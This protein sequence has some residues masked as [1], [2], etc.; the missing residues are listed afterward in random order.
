VIAEHHKRVRIEPMP[1]AVIYENPRDL[2]PGFAVRMWSVLPGA[3][4]KPGE[5]LGYG[6]TC[7]EAAREL[8]PDGMANIG[9]M[10]G[11]DP[12]IAEVW[13]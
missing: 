5:L 3:G 8:V 6:L 13:V 12:A 2:G 10:P 1:M 7:I 11:D 4:S 9:T